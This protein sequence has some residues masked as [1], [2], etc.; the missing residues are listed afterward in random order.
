MDEGKPFFEMEPIPPDQKRGWEVK[1]N[2]E[3][4]P[5]GL[6]EIRSTRFGTLTYGLRPE[7]Y[8]GWV[9]E[10]IGGGGAVTLPYTKMPDGTLL[11]GLIE[12]DRPNMGGKRLCIIGGFVNPGEKHEAAQVR[13]AAHEADLNASEAEELPGYPVNS[14]RAFFVADATKGEGVHAYAIEIPTEY[15]I[16]A[17]GSYRYQIPE[18]AKSRFGKIANVVLLPIDIAIQTTSDALALA[19]IARLAVRLDI[20]SG[21]GSY[22][23]CPALDS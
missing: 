4:M 1:I 17:G 3:Y 9:F 13:E 15:A 6:V 18:E 7:G 23:P 14:N 20:I 12:E 2:G 21:C 22:A 5:A 10:E 8:D 19:A 11:V 16:D